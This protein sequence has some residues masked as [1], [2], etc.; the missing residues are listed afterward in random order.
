MTEVLLGE[1]GRRASDSI[2]VDREGYSLAAGLALGFVT[3]GQGNTAVGLTDL[4]I[5]D[6][7]R[8]FMEG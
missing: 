1:I 4:H 6:R 2:A 7:L 8:R 5:E 3:L